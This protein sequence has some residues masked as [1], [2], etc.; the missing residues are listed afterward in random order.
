[1][2]QTQS[3]E[4]GKKGTQKSVTKNDGAY[5]FGNKTCKLKA[6]MHIMCRDR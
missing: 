6:Y 2:D 3:Q 4:R 1:M 5:I